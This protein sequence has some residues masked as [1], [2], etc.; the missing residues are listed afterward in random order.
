MRLSREVSN[1]FSINK[2]FAI[3]DL[4]ELL[5]IGLK[6]LTFSLKVMYGNLM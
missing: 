5:G 2:Y 4:L 1:N 6:S 3:L